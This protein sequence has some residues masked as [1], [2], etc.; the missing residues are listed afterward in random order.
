M[1]FNP[2]S[3]DDDGAMAFG[4]ARRGD[5]MDAYTAPEGGEGRASIGGVTIIDPMMTAGEVIRRCKLQYYFE[6]SWQVPF[7]QVPAAPLL[8][9]PEAFG[10]L[11]NDPTP[12]GVMQ[13]ELDAM[14]EGVLERI[15]LAYHLLHPEVVE[16]TR[17]R[18]M[19][20]EQLVEEMQQQALA[21]G[22][23][24]RLTWRPEEVN[25]HL[26]PADAELL[27]TDIDLHMVLERDKPSLTLLQR[28]LYTDMGLVP[29]EQRHLE[30]LARIVPDVLRSQVQSSSSQKPQQMGELLSLPGQLGTPI[31]AT[32][33]STQA[34]FSRGQ[35][36]DEA[37]KRW[38]D[39]VR[40]SFRFARTLDSHYEK[41]LETLARTKLGLDSKNQA[42]IKLTRRLWHL[43]FDGTKKNQQ[44]DVW[45]QLCR[46][47]SNYDGRP[48]AADYLERAI[49]SLNLP[50]SKMWPELLQ[51]YTELLKE[52]TSGLQGGADKRK[53]QLQI[54]GKELDPF[55][56]GAFEP[57]LQPGPMLRRVGKELGSN[58]QPAPIF[59]VEVAPLYP[60]GCD[61][62]AAAMTA[63]SDGDAA[64]LG[65]LASELHH[66]VLPGAVVSEVS[67]VSGPHALVNNTNLLVSDKLSGRHLSDGVTV[68]YHTSR[69]NTFEPLVSD[70]NNTS[71]YLFQLRNAQQD[72]TEK[73][74]APAGLA[75]ADGRHVMYRR[76]GIRNLFVKAPNAE[77]PPYERYVL[78]FN[79]EGEHKRH[80]ESQSDAEEPRAVMQRVE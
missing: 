73:S 33:D 11:L 16:E 15:P 31:H 47:S 26:E 46:F 34:T 18:A 68:S 35:Q 74:A 36:G 37:S 79:E 50:N 55:E 42:A 52:Y 60:A 67:R 12:L 10:E 80:R 45:H 20:C 13:A 3:M 14:S 64:Q 66:V 40:K 53:E 59:P 49:T 30:R 71:S 32:E 21:A 78:M 54:S 72:N 2:I 61:I 56:Q 29:Q 41:L 4:G 1:A 51:E 27:D 65:E 48:E 39:G 5:G 43:L 28:P 70:E 69:E 9:F 62:A 22:L 76:L 7:P 25:P 8:Y 19:K 24:E 77:A 23:P 6:F 58:R 75:N 57:D 63:G 44:R 17:Q 38:L